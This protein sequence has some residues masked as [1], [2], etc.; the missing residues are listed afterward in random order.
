VNCDTLRNLE[1][2][3]SDGSAVLFLLIDITQF[4]GSQQWMI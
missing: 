1:R 2:R 3:R 4:D